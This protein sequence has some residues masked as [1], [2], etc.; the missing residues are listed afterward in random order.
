MAAHLFFKCRY[1]IRVSNFL[2]S[3]LGIDSVDTSTWANFDSVK[4]WWL[5]F[6]FI[7]G[8]RRKY[9]ASL[10][11]LTSW[12]IWNKHNAR[13]FRN[14]ASMPSVIV[15]KIKGEAALWRIA[16]AKHLGSLMPRE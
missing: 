7:N 10:I 4:D 11:M 12:A 5:D 9:F 14:F 2:I 16:G 1:T 13:V 6:I 15:T 3:W 8:T